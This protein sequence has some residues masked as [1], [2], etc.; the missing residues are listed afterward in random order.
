M[1]VQTTIFTAKKIITMHPEKPFVTAVAVKDGRILGVGELEDLVHWI[2]Q[3]PFTP[4]QVDTTFQD[5]VLMPGLVDAHTHIEGQALSYSGHFI[6]QIPWPKPEGGFYKIYSTKGD[7]VQRLK[8]LDSEIPPGEV[9]YG[10]GFDDNKMGE[11]FH[12]EELDAIS[13]ERPILISNHV[14][15]RYWVNS[16]A[17]NKSGIGEGNIPKEFETDA[18][19][20]LT[21][22][23]TRSSGLRVL[24]V[25]SDQF[26]LTEQTISRIL[27]L[28]AASGN[29]TV[30]EAGFGIM[31]GLD[32]S[33]QL[34]QNV[35]TD[36]GLK[37][38]S[39]C[40]PWAA[41][42][43]EQSGSLDAFLK[44]VSEIS[45]ETNDKYRIGAIKLYADGSIISRNSHMGWPGY[46]DGTPQG[47]W[48]W[49]PEKLKEILV[50]C[51]E[52]GFST[53]T[54]ASSVPG[55]QAVL[56]GVEAAQ[57]NQYRPDMRHRVEHAFNMN[58]AQLRKAKNLG[59]CVQLYPMQIYYYGD[60]HIKIQGPDRGHN[61]A[62]TGTANRVGTSWGFHCDPPGAP[63][64]PWVSAWAAVHRKTESGVV[65]GP[66]Q[67]VSV[68]DVLRAMTI[69][70]AYHLHMDHEVGSIE[71]G[72]KADFCV[73]EAD[74]LT[75]DPDE[76]KDMPVWGT[77]FEGSPNPV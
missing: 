57:I 11:G 48:E 42:N 14:S 71:F 39:V 5:K 3:S 30:C 20:K 70:H 72:K 10:V 33:N 18:E 17:L 31:N 47:D 63:Q 62:P 41:G 13:T 45:K 35:F 26:K 61:L 76:L 37:L 60:I 55:I 58:E 16:F 40:L 7:V 2:K 68:P 44:Q 1:T 77:V 8:E 51:H 50:K 69:E 19:G 15:N 9:L 66:E 29:T 59:V 46:W 25:F 43:I 75:I 56:D 52:Y 6:A 73:L 74:P 24:S 67:R 54:H 38:R 65:L 27:P 12:R 22:T 4:Y 36:P 21:G 23:V 28:F 32:R 53:A 64:L 34:F 49:S